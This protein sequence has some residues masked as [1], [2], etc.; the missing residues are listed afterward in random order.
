MPVYRFKAWN[1]KGHS[2]T[3]KMKAPDTIQLEIELKRVGLTVRSVKEWTGESRI[4]IREILS[5]PVQLLESFARLFIREQKSHYDPEHYARTRKSRGD[6]RSRIAKG[7]SNKMPTF[8]YLAT[9]P[10]CNR[11]YGEMEATDE[12]DLTNRLLLIELKLVRASKERALDTRGIVP[13]IGYRVPLREQI[14]LAEQLEIY[15]RLDMVLPE[16]LDAV[17]IAGGSKRYRQLLLG[18]RNHVVAGDSFYAAVKR[19]PAYTFSRFFL[20]IIEVGEI[21][22]RFSGI[23]MYANRHL[24]WLMNFQRDSI[25][26]LRGQLLS[27]LFIGGLLTFVI[28]LR[29]GPEVLI[30]LLAVVAFCTLPWFRQARIDLALQLPYVREVLQIYDTLNFTH[31]FS[32][33]WSAGITAEEA[34]RKS[35]HVVYGSAMRKALQEVEEAVRLGA[36]PSESLGY[37]GFFEP[38]VAAAFQRGEATGNFEVA[39]EQ[40]YYFHVRQIDDAVTNLIGISKL[41]LYA[42]CV[43]MICVLSGLTR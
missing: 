14:I 26:A 23:F 22:G 28:A 37:T 2:I 39:L 32:I 34:I 6:I 31:L 25:Q 33:M 11:V 12:T 8:S 13:R 35:K 9:T 15:F 41:F 20:S 3:G 43:A 4:T 24:K 42:L 40:V 21:T 19:Y 17:R 30:F 16:I 18:I 10:Q 5:F 7:D 38:M 27:A 36:A 29:V 1:E